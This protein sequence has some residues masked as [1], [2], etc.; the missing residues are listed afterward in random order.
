M[1]NK[2]LKY[3]S[4]LKLLR[5]HI[6]GTVT[7]FDGALLHLIAPVKGLALDGVSAEKLVG[8]YS[9]VFTLHNRV[10]NKNLSCRI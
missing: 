6:T 2:Y 9:N 3:F 1:Y 7:N 10:I 5:A 8:R 4:Q